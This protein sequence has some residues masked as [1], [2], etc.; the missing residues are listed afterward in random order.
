MLALLSSALLPFL[1]AGFSLQ[2]PTP[3]RRGAVGRSSKCSAPQSS[4]S[5]ALEGEWNAEDIE[6]AR[7]R[8]R[9]WR[10]SGADRQHDEEPT[11]QANEAVA[12]GVDGE[13]VMRTAMWFA[14]LHGPLTSAALPTLVA[15]SLAM[16]HSSNGGGGGGSIGEGV[17]SIFQNIFRRSNEA[18]EAET[19]RQDS[20]RMQ[21]TRP[22]SEPDAGESSCPCGSGDIYE[23]CCFRL[24]SGEKV[25][26]SATE[27]L[28]ARFCAFAKG[29]PQF[30]MG[31]TVRGS[32]EWKWDQEAWS[33]ELMAFSNAYDFVE[34][35]FG[36][37]KKSKDRRSSII[38]FT[39]RM[40]D[41]KGKK[42]QFTE[43]SHFVKE[44]ETWFWSHGD[45][46]DRSAM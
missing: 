7:K 17:S 14:L 33:A 25:A 15:A 26:D 1:A 43:K 38:I 29:V 22:P 39:A 35:D 13:G 37:E 31:S 20:V 10:T 19:R 4:V 27:L 23:S 28:R 34:L 12:G 21:A 5:E 3:A 45:L 40:V 42:V 41:P 32:D 6:W 30:L 9:R 8:R 24:H 11:E 2:L 36:P 18:H 16:S 44:G 46:L